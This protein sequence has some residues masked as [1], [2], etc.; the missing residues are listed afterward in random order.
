MKDEFTTV[1]H[2]DMLAEDGWTTLDVKVLGTFANILKGI[3]KS[4]ACKNN[5]ITVEQYDE[6]IERVKKL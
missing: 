5:G 6:N 4:E 2:A 1:M 3:S